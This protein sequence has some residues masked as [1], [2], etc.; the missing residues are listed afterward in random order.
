MPGQKEYDMATAKKTPAGTWRV[1]IFLG[2]DANGVKRKKSITAP[3]KREAERAAMEYLVVNGLAKLDP[4]KTTIREALRYYIE[5]KRNVLSPST[6]YGYQNILNHRLQSVM[7][8]EIHELNS[9]NM[10]KAINE[11]A[12]TTQ[13]KTIREAKSLI[14]TALKMYG[15]NLELNVTLPPKQPV[16]KNLPTADQVIRMIRGT[17]IEL[18]C[19]LSMW[20]SLRI[21]EVRGLQFRDIQ[22]NV[23]TVQRSRISLA[24]KDVLRNVNK[25]YSSTRRL[26]V[27]PY[28]MELINAVPHESEE[29]F[30]VPMNYQVIGSHLRKLAQKNGYKL[31]LYD[32][33]HLN[34][35]VMLMLGVP[36]KYAM[37]R[38]GWAT[39]STLKSV[40]QHTFSEERKKVDKK[41]NDYFED[42]MRGLESD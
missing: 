26:L 10:Q 25:T 34:A 15:I 14:V 40:Y 3:T 31:T 9:F 38:G 8:L 42:L 36:D 6:I 19:M 30:I 39:N 12:A 28:I 27:P 35:S 7:D 37:E 23:V 16:I 4:K 21:S 41:I 17:D 29:D 11:D 32:L 33:R 2:T 22:D 13:S 1:Q 18:P 20:L 5:L 24:N